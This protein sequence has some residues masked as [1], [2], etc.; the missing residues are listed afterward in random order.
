MFETIGFDTVVVSMIVA[1]CAL[2]IGA[3][4]YLILRARPQADSPRGDLDRIVKNAPYHRLHNMLKVE[5]G[6]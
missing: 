4:A 2:S 1:T 5:A 3:S 6:S